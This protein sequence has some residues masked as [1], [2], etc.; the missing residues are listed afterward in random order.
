M[1]LRLAFMAKDCVVAFING[2]VTSDLMKEYVKNNTGKTMVLSVSYLA[3]HFTSHERLAAFFEFCL[4]AQIKI[5]LIM[6]DDIQGFNLAKELIDN[7]VKKQEVLALGVAHGKRWLA[8][9]I[10]PL[11]EKYKTVFGEVVSCADIRLWA[12]Y[13]SV[14]TI[15]MP[16][17]GE[18]SKQAI[19]ITV[20][21][22]IKRKLH[23]LESDYKQKRRRDKSLVALPDDEDAKK[24]FLEKQLECSWTT[25]NHNS[26]CFV[27]EENFLYAAILMKYAAAEIFYPGVETQAFKWVRQTLSSQ[28]FPIAGYRQYEIKEREQAKLTPDVLE[29]VGLV[30]RESLR[31]ELSL[32]L[33]SDP[34]LLRPRVDSGGRSPDSERPDC[35]L[36]EPEFKRPRA[37]SEGRSSDSELSDSSTDEFE[38]ATKNLINGSTASALTLLMSGTLPTDRAQFLLATLAQRQ[39][40]LE[41][42]AQEA[43]AR[44]EGGKIAIALSAFGA[45]SLTRKLPEARSFLPSQKPKK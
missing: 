10:D 23:A 25:L 34:E 3:E 38:L 13:Q 31:Q 24:S 9:Y 1:A 28:R 18:E 27:S 40:V 7:D 2:I 11:R 4:K 22:Y 45:L 16:L 26:T 39:V 44:A 5:D 33:S 17:L 15:L 29:R 19:D 20:E 36:P 21:N 6:I 12:E 32:L 43:K 14:Q 30:D 37:D 41:A 8:E 42:E 35:L